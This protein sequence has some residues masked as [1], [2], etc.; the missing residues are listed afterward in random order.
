MRGDI[1]DI[2][3]YLRKVKK[4]VTETFSLIHSYNDILDWETDTSFKDD[5]EYEERKEEIERALRREDEYVENIFSQNFLSGTIL[6]FAY[7]G[8]KRFS[9]NINIPP[10]YRDIQSIKNA[11]QFIIGREIEDIH[12]GLIIYIGR[13]QWAHHWEKKL[14]EPNVSLFDRLATWYS[15]TFNKYYKSPF[16]DLRNEHV[17]IFASNLLHLID[18]SGFEDF[19]KDM[20]EMAKGF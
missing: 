12:I 20:L 9:K 5:A 11:S 3:T 10:Q 8:I 15:V 2:D 18:W 1:R 4:S 16:Y 19:E 17:D 7:A 14:N 6:Q 13:N